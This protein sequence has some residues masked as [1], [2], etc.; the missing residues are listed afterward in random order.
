[1]NQYVFCIILSD[2]SCNKYESRRLI[3]CMNF[4]FLSSNSEKKKRVSRINGGG[5]RQFS[6][7]GQWFESKRFS[8]FC[9]YKKERSQLFF[10]PSYWSPI[11]FQFIVL[12]LKVIYYY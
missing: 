11:S 3:I 5:L 1:M 9:L 4:I 6:V 7:I 12:R 10:F 8:F 2:V